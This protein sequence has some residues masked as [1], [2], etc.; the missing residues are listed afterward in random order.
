[1]CAALIIKDNIRLGASTGD[2]RLHEAVIRRGVDRIGY[3]PVRAAGAVETMRSSSATRC[4]RLRH[5]RRQDA[6][7]SARLEQ[8]GGDVLLPHASRSPH[9]LSAASN[10][11]TSLNT[12][13]D[14]EV[15]T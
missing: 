12:S 3:G 11:K 9:S 5:S 15:S 8:S 6:R 4:A 1:M 10:S 14:A 7:P 2:R 13:S